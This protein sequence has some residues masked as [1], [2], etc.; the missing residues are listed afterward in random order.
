MKNAT[1]SD[2]RKHLALEK[3]NSEETEI[4]VQKYRKLAGIN[5]HQFD[6]LIDKDDWTH[7]PL[8]KDFVDEIVNNNPKIFKAFMNFRG[9]LVRKYP[10]YKYLIERDDWTFP[11]EEIFLFG[12]IQHDTETPF[13]NISWFKT[14][15]Q[16][17]A[18]F[19]KILPGADRQQ[20]IDFLDKSENRID[21]K[22]KKLGIVVPKVK[23]RIKKYDT[24]ALDL[25]VRVLNT[26]SSDEIRDA[27]ALR[28][29][30]EYKEKFTYEGRR[31]TFSRAKYELIAEYVIHRFGLKKP[32]G[33]AY[34]ADY[35]KS[36][37]KK[38]KN[39]KTKVKSGLFKKIP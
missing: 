26:F 36:I 29:P 19:I 7:L 21:L 20:V 22:F 2:K 23:A 10:E 3:I 8:R 13:D 24:Y 27:F 17:K 25:W 34:Y 39:D 5:G 33:K 6:F 9:A 15:D 31:K 28:Y 38:A 30:K 14:G 18:L 37:L 4:I 12:D 35:I 16:E 1:P 32:N 11:V